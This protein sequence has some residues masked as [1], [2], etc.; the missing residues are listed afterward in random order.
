VTQE[1]KTNLSPPSEGGLDKLHR[2]TKASIAAVPVV[3]GSAAEVFDMLMLPP[4]EARR[5]EWREAVG[6]EI[7]RLAA[8]NDGL[9]ERLTN[10]P[11]FITVVAH[12]SQIALR[13][14]HLDK[15][16]A[17]RNAI[18]NSATTN[19]DDSKQHKF[20]D[21][22]E[23]LTP[24]HIAILKFFQSPTVRAG[25]S[26]GGLSHVLE[27]A[28]PELKGQREFYDMLWKD[29]FGNS[30]VNTEMVHVT[31]T[32]VGLTDKRTTRFADEFLNYIS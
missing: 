24:L 11:E 27:D 22:I 28:F 12:A 31:M 8:E 18:K 32:A 30:L 2:A 16:E 5:N 20:L 10:S 19:I 21:L 17:L 7:T 4:I 15:L 13:T 29:L 14:H 1:S 3:G 23:T 9:V 25:M 26:M 6:N